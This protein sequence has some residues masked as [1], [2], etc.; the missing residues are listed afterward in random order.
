[1]LLILAAMVCGFVSGWLYA[2]DKSRFPLALVFAGRF[3]V[4][5]GLLSLCDGVFKD[6]FFGESFGV[7]Y[8]NIVAGV[9]LIRKARNA[10]DENDG[11]EP[12]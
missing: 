12:I 4:L 9:V 6:D 5:V 7:A 3:F 1:M 10:E 11:K 2:Y 8:L